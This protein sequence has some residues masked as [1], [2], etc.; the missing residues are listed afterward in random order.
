M[1]LI[2]FWFLKGMGWGDVTPAHPGVVL[3][4]KGWFLSYNC[5]KIEYKR[6]CMRYLSFVEGRRPG[7]RHVSPPPLFYLYLKYISGIQMTMY[8]KTNSYKGHTKGWMTQT[9]D[10]PYAVSWRD[11]RQKNLIIFGGTFYVLKY[12]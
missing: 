11:G 7:R 12:A 9:L 1:G 10:Y 5:I 8:V 3:K 2:D 4:T 6:M